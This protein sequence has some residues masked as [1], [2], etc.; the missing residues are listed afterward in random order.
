MSD[1][2]DLDGIRRHAHWK[3]LLADGFVMM[4]LGFLAVALPNLGASP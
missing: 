3:R 4:I 2:P 1:L